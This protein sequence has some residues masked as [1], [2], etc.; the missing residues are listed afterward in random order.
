MPVTA[1]VSVALP[2]S[3]A[4]DCQRHPQE[5]VEDRPLLPRHSALLVSAPHVAI[6]LKTETRMRYARHQAC[7]GDI[8]DR[9]EQVGGAGTTIPLR[10]ASWSAL[11]SE[12]QRKFP[13]LTFS[14]DDSTVDLD[15]EALKI[16]QDFASG[17]WRFTIMIRVG[18][19]PSGLYED[20]AQW[21]SEKRSDGLG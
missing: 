8:Q 18:D 21:A 14:D 9:R 5:R 6:Q 16:L 1:E 10:A 4:R 15:E 17:A 12:L 19:W 3:A 7:A 2:H 11:S 13:E 20:P